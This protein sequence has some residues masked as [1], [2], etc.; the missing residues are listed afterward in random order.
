MFG[1]IDG[2]LATCSPIVP[3]P[4]YPLGSVTPMFIISV[5]FEGLPGFVSVKEDKAKFT[6]ERE[7]VMLRLLVFCPEKLVR[8]VVGT[9]NNPARSEITTV[10]VGLYSNLKD[11]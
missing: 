1:E 5:E 6:A 8:P 7:P 2:A 11:G 4:V 10:I 3:V 9:L